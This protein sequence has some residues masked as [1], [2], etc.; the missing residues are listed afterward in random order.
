MNCFEMC[1]IGFIAK[2]NHNI[3]GYKYRITFIL[4]LTLELHF[5]VSDMIHHPLYADYA[6]LP[7]IYFAKI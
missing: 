1:K 2:I 4:F 7:F 6:G 5:S 3:A